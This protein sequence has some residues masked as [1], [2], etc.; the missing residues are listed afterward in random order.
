AVNNRAPYADESVALAV[1]HCTERDVDVVEAA[2]S[3]LG[4]LG[5][6][7]G[8]EA[9]LAHVGHDSA[10]VRL[11]VAWTLPSL[12]TDDE[13][14]DPQAPQG[15]V[16]ALIRLT[17]DPEAQVRDWATF[18]LGVQLDVDSGLIRDTLAARLDDLEK[19]TAGEALVG[20]ARRGDMRALPRLLEW[21]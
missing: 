12:L 13:L 7:R 10:A 17:T 1:E 9:V 15:L 2:I 4:H 5:D 18:G 6:A 3:A 14:E 8:L 19:D 20:L 11:A 21:L 16:D